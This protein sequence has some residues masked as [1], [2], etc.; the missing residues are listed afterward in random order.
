MIGFNG[1][2]GLSDAA[3]PSP[4][5]GRA[6]RFDERPVVTDTKDAVEFSSEAAEAAQVV[7]L[8]SNGQTNDELRAARIEQ[9]RENLQ[10]GTHKIQEVVEIVAARITEYIQHE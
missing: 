8:A 9:A 5:T 10:N 2:G 1:I 3:N 7:R 6:R 4:S